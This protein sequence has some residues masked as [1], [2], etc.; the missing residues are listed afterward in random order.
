M[1]RKKSLFYK[2]VTWSIIILIMLIVGIYKFIVTSNDPMAIDKTY[3][4]IEP[5]SSYFR[6]KNHT[7]ILHDWND[8]ELIRR[9][10]KRIGYGEHGST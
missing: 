9:D 3:I 4:Y 5:F 7:Q 8:Y 2:C 10:E 1:K 6:R